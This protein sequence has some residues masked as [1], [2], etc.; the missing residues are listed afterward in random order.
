M[1]LVDASWSG[2]CSTG[3]SN[4]CRDHQAVLISE[5]GKGVCTPE[6]CRRLIEA[7][8]KAGIPVIVDPSSSGDC[9][10]FVGA[11]AVTPNRLETKRAT[12]RAIA[13][14]DDAIA[15]GRRLCAELSLD[16]AFITL[17]SDGIVVAAC[18]TARPEHL[19]TR[20]RE[21]YDI[22]GA[23]DMVLATIGLG[24]AAGIAPFDLARL[25]QRGRRVGSRADRRRPHHA[26]ANPGR[27]VRRR[28]VD[29]RQNLHAR[30]S[31]TARRRPP[32]AGKTD[33]PHERLLRPVARGPRHLFAA[34][35][36]RGGLPDRGDQQRRQR[37]PA[38]QGAGSA[39][40]QRAAAGRDAGRA[41]S[42]RL[43]HQ[44]SARRRRTPCSHGSSPTCL[45]KGELTRRTK[46]SAAR[47]SIAYGGQV[48]ALA[49]IPGMSIDSRARTGPR[50][51]GS[52]IGRPPDENRPVSS[53]LDRRRRDGDAG[54]AGAAG[55]LRLG[56][57]WSLF[58]APHVA[59]VLAGLDL[60]DRIILHDPRGRQI[61]AR[62]RR[63]VRKL[64]GE[65]FDL[66]LLF[67]NSLRSAWLAWR[68][69]AK[70]R[71]GFSRDG[72]GILL[73]DALTPKSRRSPNPVLDEFSRLAAHVG[74]SVAQRRTEAAVLPENEQ[75]LARFWSQYDPRWLM[76]G[77]CCLNPGGAFGA[78][79]HWPTEYFADLARRIVDHSGRTVLVLCGP[80]EREQARR[81][82]DESKRPHVVSFADFPTSIGLT[83]AAIRSAELL[84]T[85]DSGPRHFAQ[86]FGFQSS[87][88][89]GRRTRPGA[90]PGSARGALAAP[91][92]CGP[93][94]QRECPLK[95]HR[96][97][98]DLSV[99]RVYDAVVAQLA[100][101][102][103]RV[104]A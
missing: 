26:A 29:D 51:E 91:V 37:P 6:I 64:R 76:A 14:I 36:A 24:S 33:R 45:S 53:E 57:K 59:D 101:H 40:L 43:R 13:T 9:R 72:R 71:V 78:A 66:A 15:A 89:S 52:L 38:R 74:C 67:T 50:N 30:R 81:I 11:T 21:V 27:P 83:K 104:A 79:K 5:Y 31:G 68:S 60:I 2:S 82:A 56:R 70:R 8:R 48:K 44:S 25:G 102:A 87:R 97:M 98:R 75:A 28:A 39:H 100:R 80:A 96:C 95:H 99:D 22:T 65:R 42:G 10:N 20:K 7:A 3:C 16:H 1:P 69:G 32:P 4:R 47:W 58:P 85:T 93:C 77:V 19:P 41:R 88:S 54:L 94:Q 35:R 34:G 46:S 103:R 17:D 23:G 18:P 62:G 73:T 12:G 55:D 61:D 90:T 63:L 92:D 49:H 84:V 86:P